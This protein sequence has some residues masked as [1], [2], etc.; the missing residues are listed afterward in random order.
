MVFVQNV[1]GMQRLADQL[2][3]LGLQDPLVFA[4]PRGGVP[5]AVEVAERLR[6]PMDLILVRKI[7]AP[8][9][10]ELALGA[11]V[12]GEE[13]QVVMN[14]EIVRVSGADAEFIANARTAQVA[15]LERRR[16]HYVGNRKRLDPQGRTA[17][18][19]DD[20]LATGA[21]MKAALTALRRNGAHRVVVALPVA[22]VEALEEIQNLTDDIV[23]LLPAK[24][25]RGV[26]AFYRDFHHCVA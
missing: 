20:G 9:N 22:P 11:I 24:R 15:E 14:D 23:C 19:V 5:V 13:P 2:A 25:F 1:Y 6:A 12:E 7:G 3:V 16:R 17:V 8:H 10:P 26:G 21:T 18:V 4:L